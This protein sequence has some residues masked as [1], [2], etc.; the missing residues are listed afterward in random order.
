MPP[1][2]RSIWTSLASLII[3]ALALFVLIYSVWSMDYEWSY[4]YLADYFWQPSENPAIPGGRPGLLLEGLWGTIRISSISIFLGSIWGT[5]L[6]LVLYLREPVS[7]RAARLVV[8]IF[9]NTPLLVQL[10]VAYFVIGTAFSIEAEPAGILTLSLFCGAYIAEITRGQL[11]TFEKGQLE[12]AA[13]LGLSPVQTAIHIVLP[14]IS[15]RMMPPLVGQ[16]V[17]LVKDSSLVSVI[18]IM[19]LT[20]AGLNI[21]SVSFKSFETWFVIA[22]LYFVLNQ[23]VASLGAWLEHHLSRSERNHALDVTK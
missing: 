2:R 14:Q 21:V 13:S 9:R 4:A 5:L 19:E 3:I 7:A 20:K 23:L 12:A 8:N 15:R 6:G 10:Y 17:S 1:R 18:S 16:F 22:A 11:D